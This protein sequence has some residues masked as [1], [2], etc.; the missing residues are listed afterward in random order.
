MLP[1]L[2]VRS[3]TV[4]SMDNGSETLMLS[5][6]ISMCVDCGGERIFVPTDEGGDLGGDEFCC[7]SCDSAV[8][9]LQVLEN[10]RTPHRRVA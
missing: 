3:D 8:F 5:G 10:T 6:V 2:S 9:L 7:T 4:S 1:K